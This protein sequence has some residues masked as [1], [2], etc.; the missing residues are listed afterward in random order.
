MEIN[1]Y[2]AKLQG[3]GRLL[4]NGAH[5]ETKNYWL[6]VKKKS[7]EKDGEY[8]D[9]LF[10]ERNGKIHDHWGIKG[11]CINDKFYDIK[12]FF[13]NDRGEIIRS[14]ERHFQNELTD[15]IFNREIFERD[16]NKRLGSNI[17][18][19][20]KF[21]WDSSNKII[22]IKKISFREILN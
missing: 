6:E 15:E 7:S 14:F 12:M 8:F 21:H 4:N 16:L 17:K 18:L 3:E 10:G 11:L 22:Q 5:M 2:G 1:E 13:F 19:Y 9:F 20:V